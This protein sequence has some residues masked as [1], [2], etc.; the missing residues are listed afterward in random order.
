MEDLATDRIYRLMLAQRLQHRA[1]RRLP[2]LRRSCPVHSRTAG[3]PSTKNSTPSLLN[4]R[5]A[6]SV[7][8]KLCRKGA[9]SPRR[10]FLTT[11]SIRQKDSRASRRQPSVASVG[12]KSRRPPGSSNSRCARQSR[13]W[14]IAIV[15]CDRFSNDAFPSRNLNHRAENEFFSLSSILFSGCVRDRAFPC[16]PSNLPGSLLQQRAV[17]QADII[18]GA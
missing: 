12:V 15:G 9:V 10:W 14:V 11:N 16:L 2:I 3:Q 1:S 8:L 7:I 17:R 6:R 18:Q 5:A 4:H 13:K